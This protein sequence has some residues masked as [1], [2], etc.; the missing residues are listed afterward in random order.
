M[1]PK[2]KELALLRTLLG[3][4]LLHTTA[5]NTFGKKMGVT[6]DNVAS[7]QSEGFK[8]SRVDLTEGPNNTVEAEI[9][10]IDSPGNAA[11][12]TGYDG[13][14]VQK[15]LSNVDPAEEI[16]RATIV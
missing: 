10:R 9:N 15:E 5:L 3:W 11:H 4:V 13:Q 2:F 6:A 16:P 1:E 14:M 8:K 12:E 7:V